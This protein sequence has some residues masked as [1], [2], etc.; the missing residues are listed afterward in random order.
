M[1]NG[2]RDEMISGVGILLTAGDIPVDTVPPG[3][4]PPPPR[5]TWAL[6]GGMS[7]YLTHL[8]H[9]PRMARFSTPYNS[10]ILKMLEKL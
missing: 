3:H 6:T 9:Q 8:C 10:K 4:Y 1:H 7:V 2:I 5:S